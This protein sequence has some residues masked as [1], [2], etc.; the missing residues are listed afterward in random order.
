MVTS[1]VKHWT[2]SSVSQIS[3]GQI[4]FKGHCSRRTV[5][6]GSVRRHHKPYKDLSSQWQENWVSA[7]VINAFPVDD[8]TERQ[9]WFNLPWPQW[10]LLNWFRTGQGHCRACRKRLGLADIWLWCSSNCLTL[11]SHVL[12]QN[13]KV[14]CALCS[15]W[16]GNRLADILWLW[17]I[18]KQQLASTITIQNE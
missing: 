7:S 11:L 14:I 2:S 10:C 4:P 17:S 3:C 8:P 16:T 5:R 6:T 13:W 9:P 1:T 18:C 12:Q 15:W